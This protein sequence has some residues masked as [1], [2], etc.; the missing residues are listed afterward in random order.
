M[1]T[2]ALIGGVTYTSTNWP[3]SGQGGV[4]A[5][6]IYHAGEW[7]TA[8]CSIYIGNL[9]SGVACAGIIR[10]EGVSLQE[11]TVVSGNP[12]ASGGVTNDEVFYHFAPVTAVYTGVSGDISDYDILQQFGMYASKLITKQGIKLISTNIREWASEEEPEWKQLII[13]FEVEA[14]SDIALG[15]WD[16]LSDE[17]GDFLA[18]M[19]D[20]STPDLR[21]LI[22][23]T[24]QWK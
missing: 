17:L 20:K 13:D 24:V 2:N 11:A 23:I 15:L 19:R 3:A 10:G 14:K 1:V 6:T 22:S 7:N 8:Y 4:F 16:R 21:D 12:W 9:G 18:I 5:G